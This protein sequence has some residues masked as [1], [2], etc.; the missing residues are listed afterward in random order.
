M[1]ARVA[2]CHAQWG[3]LP[4]WFVVDFVEYGD[5]YGAVSQLNLQGLP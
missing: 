5:V 1:L 2:D 3:R 4:S